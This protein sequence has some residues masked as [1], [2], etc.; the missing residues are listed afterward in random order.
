[1]GANL[2]LVVDDPGGLPGG[3]VPKSLGGFADSVTIGAVELRTSLLPIGTASQVG[4]IVDCP[5]VWSLL[6]HSTE[7]RDRSLIME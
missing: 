6:V 1:L 3:I 7:L 4:Q 2:S 5:R